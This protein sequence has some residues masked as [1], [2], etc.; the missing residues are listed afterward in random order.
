MDPAYDPR[1]NQI[2]RNQVFSHGIRTEY[3]LNP[4]R[5]IAAMNQIYGPGN[6]RYQIAH[7]EYQILVHTGAPVYLL[8]ELQKMGVALTDK[9][10]EQT[11]S[12]EKEQP[13]APS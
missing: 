2:N 3:I 1:G 4:E 7:G 13:P 9:D 5:F 10:L 6:Y 11:A 12:P 8:D